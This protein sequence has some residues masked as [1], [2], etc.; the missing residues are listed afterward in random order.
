MNA[1]GSNLRLLINRPGGI[2]YPVGPPD[3]RKLAYTC[4]R[5]RSTEVFS[6]VCSMN[7]DGTTED[8]LTGKSGIRWASWASWRH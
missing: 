8:R 3:A 5:L 2:R 4:W 6:L 1:D 7:A